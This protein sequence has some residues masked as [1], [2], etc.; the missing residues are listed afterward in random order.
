MR[1]RARGQDKQSIG[2]NGYTAGVNITFIFFFGGRGVYL[3]ARFYYKL[4]ASEN[5]SK[6]DL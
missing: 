2:L 6:E 5:I 1:Q 4:D 3:I